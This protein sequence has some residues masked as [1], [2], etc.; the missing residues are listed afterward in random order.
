MAYKNNSY[1]VHILC[2]FVPILVYLLVLPNVAIESYTDNERYSWL[3]AE[4]SNES[5]FSG[6]NRGIIN[7]GMLELP[8]YL[9]F[10]FSAKLGLTYNQFINLSC[11]VLITAFASLTRKRKYDF[12]QIFLISFSF[13]LFRLIIDLHKLKFGFIF[14]L[15]GASVFW[16]LS[17]VFF[18]TQFILVFLGSLLSKLWS[19]RYRILRGKISIGLIFFLSTALL[20]IFFTMPILTRKF[21]Y[22]FNQLQFIDFIVS[23]GFIVISRLICPSIGFLKY[24]PILFA[25]LFVGNSR[26]NILIYMLMLTGK[27]INF[28]LKMLMVFLN[29]YLWSNFLSSP[30]YEDLVR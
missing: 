12:F 1:L 24:V 5:I 10:H 20:I 8:S 6:Y 9:I 26:L 4:I 11:V 29:F 13:Y 30:L 21:M 27:P 2:W 19:F 23:T 18:H 3:Y 14:Y 7:L 25:V 17:A 22:Y 16:Q 28:P 15:L